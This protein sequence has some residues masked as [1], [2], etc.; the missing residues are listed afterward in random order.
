M[1]RGGRGAQ[2]RSWAHGT[3]KIRYRRFEEQVGLGSFML[4]KTVMIRKYTDLGPAMSDP[5]G[6]RAG[7]PF[8]L[9]TANH[10]GPAKRDT[11]TQR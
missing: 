9:L 5:G 8:Q 11:G 7:A 1:E 3:G 4:S 10:S 6:A 2:I